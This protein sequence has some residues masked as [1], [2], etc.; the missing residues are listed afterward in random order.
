MAYGA[1]MIDAAKNAQKYEDIFTKLPI[2]EQVYQANAPDLITSQNQ[3][4]L[5]REKMD[6]I[7][8]VLRK[9]SGA[10]ISPSEFSGQDKIFFPQP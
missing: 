7:T 5:M 1:R 3:K 6:F 2:A 10:A 9:E 8:A 4:S